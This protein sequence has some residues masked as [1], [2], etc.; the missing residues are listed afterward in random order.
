M[1]KGKKCLLLVLIFFNFFL[2]TEWLGQVHAQ[3]KY[4]VR[5]IDIIVPLGAG[6]SCDL[7]NRIAAAYVS[8]KWGVPVNV[9]NKPGGNSM[10]GCIEAYQATPD[11][12]TLLGDGTASSYML[13]VAIKN[14][15]LKV[16]DR[17]FI[18]MITLAPQMVVV[19][20]NSPFK[21]LKD[22]EAEAKRD[23]DSFTW[24]SQGGVG[25]PDAVTRQFLYTIGV[26]VKRTKPVIGTG[27]AD[28]AIFTAGGHVKM[29]IVTTASGYAGI[30][31]GLMRALA[32]ADT[33]RHPDYPEVPTAAEAGYP[34]VDFVPWFGLS[35]PP[36]LP[37][38]VVD[39][40]NRALQE[41]SKD[42]EQISKMKKTGLVPFYHNSK[43]L[44]D[45]VIKRMSEVEKL[46]GLK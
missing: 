29:G 14:L 43:E 38:Y 40:W 44:R 9:I 19:P 31:G 42:P 5:P 23:P 15:P 24:S 25:G 30:K 46:W 34:A 7:T 10:P 11:G 27:G 17:T 37:S 28:M 45:H 20:S 16:L 33:S 3:T 1:F 4:P 39:M 41:M 13:V 6:G 22:I 35:G 36:N 2:L 8:K 32:I 18:S 12:Y 21:S 26:D